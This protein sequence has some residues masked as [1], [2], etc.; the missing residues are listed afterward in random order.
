MKT[1]NTHTPGP[2]ESERAHSGRVIYKEIQRDFETKETR[3]LAFMVRNGDQFP[4]EE[5]DANASLIAAS[6]D[7]LTA[8]E[9]SMRCMGDY[10]SADSQEARDYCYKDLAHAHKQAIQA[11]AKAKGAT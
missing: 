7:L 5:S 6:P 8:L 9:W 10:L 4:V 2:W 1:Q 11:I 3:M